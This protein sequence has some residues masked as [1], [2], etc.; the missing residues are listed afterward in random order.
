MTPLLAGTI[1]APGDVL[2]IA[3][4]A[5]KAAHGQCANIAQPTSAI[6]GPSGS[7]VTKGGRTGYR[8]L[9]S[10]GRP[11]GLLGAMS[12]PKPRQAARI[13]IVCRTAMRIT[14]DARKP[15]K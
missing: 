13:A 7:W 11:P 1:S 3:M 8:R 2:V 6:D 9:G 5:P 10:S 14:I 12:H 4:K 15:G